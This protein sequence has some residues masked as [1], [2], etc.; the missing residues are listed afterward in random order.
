MLEWHLKLGRK[1]FFPI[2][3]L[4]IDYTYIRQYKFRAAGRANGVARVW[5]T[6][7]V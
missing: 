4:L 1:L 5:E 6:R 7:K 3:S 2:F